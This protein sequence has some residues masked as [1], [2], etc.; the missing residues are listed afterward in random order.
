MGGS[1]WSWVLV[2]E[3]GY[4]ALVRRLDSEHST[5]HLFVTRLLEIVTH[6]HLPPVKSL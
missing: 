4:V 5:E 2:E 6:R 1:P 3:D